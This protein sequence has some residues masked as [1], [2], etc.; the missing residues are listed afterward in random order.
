MWKFVHHVISH[1]LR[2]LTCDA[3]WV[4]KLHDHSARRAWP[5]DSSDEQERRWTTIK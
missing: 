4:M 3:E 1:P 2:W 5:L